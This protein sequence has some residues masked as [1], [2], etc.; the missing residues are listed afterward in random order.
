MAPK[1]PL[2]VAQVVA[3]PMPQS[4]VTLRDHGILNGYGQPSSR[5]YGGEMHWKHQGITDASARTAATYLLHTDP[6]ER[7]LFLDMM[8]AG[9]A[10]PTNFKKVT[11]Q[12]QSVLDDLHWEHRTKFRR[13]DAGSVIAMDAGGVMH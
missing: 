2:P 12:Y 8:V 13:L 3:P 11:H 5:G 10:T 6:S 1:R 7:R 9:G 4:L